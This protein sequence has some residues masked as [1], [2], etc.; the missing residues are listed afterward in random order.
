MAGTQKQLQKSSVFSPS[1][2]GDLYALDNLY[3]SPMREN[4]VWNFSQVAQ[5]SLYNLGFL[6]MRSILT[7]G[8]SK[9]AISVGGFTPGF[10]RGLSKIDGFENW[11]RFRT[12]GFIPRV[13]GKEF[14]LAMNSEIH[15]I[16]NPALASYEKELFEEWNPKAVSILG[17]WENQEILM[18]GVSLPEDEKNLPKLLKDLIQTLSGTCGKF[19]LRTDKHSYLCLKKDKDNLGPVFFQ[20]KEKVWDSFVF[21]ILEKEVS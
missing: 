19:Y 18:T 14:P 6:C 13:I 21:L 8:R 1:G 7:S 16:L 17:T 5:F 4:E 10:V 12:E 11:N 9:D 3:L 2:H 20:E 15:P